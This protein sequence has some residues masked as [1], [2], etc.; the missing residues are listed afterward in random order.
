MVGTMAQQSHG[1][2]GPLRA[3]LSAALVLF[4]AGLLF[5][6]NARLTS[7]DETR[8]PENFG[9]LVEQESVRGDDLFAEVERLRASVKELTLLADAQAP[10]VAPEIAA[11]SGIATGLAPVVGPGLSVTLQDAPA[12]RIQPENVTPDDLVVHQEDL[13]GVINALW[14][15]G[16]EAMT[17]AGQRVTTLSAFRCVGNVLSLHGRVYSPPYEV[18]AIGDP[19]ALMDALDASDPVSLYRQYV[20][21]VGLGWDVR[22]LDAVEMPA[23]DG[24]LDLEF[25]SVPDGTEIY[26]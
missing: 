24:A 12:S 25:A 11:R 6:A 20:E 2:R 7:G 3:S 22:A 1:R 14:A 26:W 10:R 8:H 17:L 15:G 5:V 16:A 23:Y 13:E 9:D 18:K 19:E 4:M 21:Y